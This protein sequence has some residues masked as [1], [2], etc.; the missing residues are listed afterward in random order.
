MLLDLHGQPLS[1]EAIDPR[2]P[3]AGP[4][5]SSPYIATQES[6]SRGFMWTFQ[7]DTRR[8]LSRWSRTTLMVKSRTLVEN[9]GPAKAL[10]NLA[11]LIGSL[12]PQSLCADAKWAALA[13]ARFEEISSSSLIF[14]AGGR[15]T[16]QT[17]QPF[18]TFRRFTDGDIFDIF[19]E[20]SSRTARIATREAH[21]V[22]NPETTLTDWRD[23]VRTNRDGFPLA[24]GFARGTEGGGVDVLPGLNVHHHASFTTRG[25]VRGTPALAHFINDAHDLMEIKGFQKQAIKTAALMGLTRKS[26]TGVNGAPPGIYGLAADTGT[27]IYQTASPS[28]PSTASAASRSV[29]YEDVFSGGLVSSVPLD[30]LHDDRPHPNT[31]LHKDSLLR[32][33]AIGLGAPPSI[34]FFMEDKGGA[35]ARVDL[36]IFAKFVL[37]QHANHLLPFCQRYWTYAIAKEMKEGRLPY[38]SRG[39]FWKVRWTPPRSL[40][41]DLGKMG[42]LLINL[43]KALLTT[44]A[45]HYEEMGLHYEDELEQAAKEAALLISLEKKYKLPPGTMLNALNQPNVAAA[46]ATAGEQAADSKDGEESESDSEDETGAES[47]AE[48]TDGEDEAAEETPPRKSP[49]KPSKK[50]GK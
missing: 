26:E 44:Y 48:D 32:E 9:Y 8:Q 43:R 40:T 5:A 20:T 22:L 27:S 19:T 45:R 30:T 23:G 36:D 11:R 42:S 33:A 47:G 14:D 24:Y 34:V 4:L 31:L 16:F 18:T 38:P 17:H 1:P 10:W 46:P 13:E 6:S 37:D 21:E 12:K 41:A 7:P 29:N 3:A 35:N 28:A 2:G 25:A 15:F 49:V 39:D 50:A